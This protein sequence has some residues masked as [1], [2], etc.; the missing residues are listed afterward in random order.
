MTLL[1]LLLPQLQI[2]SFIK[3]KI[4]K[5]EMD[6]VMPALVT[7]SQKFILNFQLKFYKETVQRL[8]LKKTAVCWPKF[9]QTFAK[10]DYLIL[11]TFLIVKL[12]SIE[13]YKKFLER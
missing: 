12:P 6:S 5:I 11:P 8:F 10:T 9:Y 7:V 3:L 4:G 2:I 13:V 1:L